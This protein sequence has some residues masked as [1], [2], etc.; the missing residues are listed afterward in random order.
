MTIVLEAVIAKLVVDQAWC[1]FEAENTSGVI[2]RRKR[3]G[4][5]G[6]PELPSQPQISV[7]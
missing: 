2:M 3:E 1:S 4:I 6:T 5:G 7:N